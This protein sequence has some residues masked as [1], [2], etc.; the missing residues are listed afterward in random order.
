MVGDL[1]RRRRQESLVLELLPG[2]LQVV[3]EPATGAGVAHLDELH[4]IHQVVEDHRLHPVLGVGGEL[5]SAVG[6]IA[7]HRLRKADVALL[8]DLHELTVAALILMG[9]LHHEAEIGEDECAGRVDVA[10]RVVA[11]SQRL[12]LL[13][14][15][16]FYLLELR[17][18]GGQRI[19]REEQLRRRGREHDGPLRE[20]THDRV[21]RKQQGT[22]PG[23][24]LRLGHQFHFLCIGFA[25]GCGGQ[26]SHQVI[27]GRGRETRFHC[28]FIHTVPSW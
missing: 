19:A 5:H 26:Q 28:G 15:Q 17:E 21:G 2:L 20:H 8:D 16:D 23:L 6:I 24:Q 27:V 9:N 1:T 13:C 14:R 7:F 11:F 10:A 22:Q 3:E 18:V 4:G 12:L 25:L